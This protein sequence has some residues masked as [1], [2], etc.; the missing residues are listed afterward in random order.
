MHVHQNDPS[1]ITRSKTDRPSLIHAQSTTLWLSRPSC[2]IR[3]RVLGYKKDPSMQALEACET[4]SSIVLQLLALTLY[5]LEYEWSGRPT[6]QSF[7]QHSPSAS[8][9]IR[10]V[11]SEH[12]SRQSSPDSH[13]RPKIAWGYFKETIRILVKYQV[14]T[15]VMV[16]NVLE[17]SGHASC[18]EC[19]SERFVGHVLKLTAGQTHIGKARL[20]C[21]VDYH[22]EKFSLANLTQTNTS[23][24]ATSKD[25]YPRQ[26]HSGTAYVLRCLTKTSIPPLHTR[27]A[28]ILP[29]S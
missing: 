28:T 13:T 5:T 14:H 10:T 1:N 19:G 25:A 24:D 23:T 15:T 20:L 16:L 26:S 29:P 9:N 3:D 8:A 6:R 18:E 2:R 27:S 17:H 7:K 21:N 22:Q 4:A 11:T 12:S